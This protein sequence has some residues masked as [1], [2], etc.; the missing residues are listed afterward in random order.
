MT[1]TIDELG[2]KFA[3]PYR[4]E[5]IM[6]LIAELSDE[7]KQT[8][9]GEVL[10]REETL[11][12]WNLWARPKQ[13]IPDEPYYNVH[14]LL[15]GRGF[16]KTRTMAEWI[17]KKAYEE[18]GCRIG[19]LGRTAADSR[20]IMVTG[21]SGILNIPQPESQKP[22]YKSSEAMVKY[23]NG[24][25]VKLMSA[26]NPDGT[27]GQQFNYSVVDE[28]AAHTPFVGVDGLTA[29]Q[30]L[31]LATRLGDRP[32]LV[33]ATTPKKVK[34]LRDLVE[35]SKDPSKSIRLVKGK[36]SENSAN[37]SSVYMD[38]IHGS[39]D[40]T[41]IAR[42][43][44]DGEML[45]DEIE[46]ALWS[47]EMIK[48]RYIARDEAMR[49]PLR[50]V[51]VDPTVAERPND[52]CGIVVVGG[53]V[54]PLYHRRKGYVLA[55]E[56]LKASP[57]V[58][59]Q[60]VIDTFYEWKAH[61]IVVEKNQG[62]FLLKMALKNIDPAVASRIFLVN[63][64]VS[65]KLRA[66][67]ISQIYEQ[68]RILHA[69]PGYPLLESQMTTWEPEIMKNSPDRID[70]LVHGMTALL[71]E[72]PKGLRRRKMR[73]NSAAAGARLPTGLGTGRTRTATPGLTQT[74]F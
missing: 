50:I 48:Y 4:I 29:F 43:E 8:Y 66:E 6:E 13:I 15:A 44:L 28:F 9:F 12:D 45:D 73:A 58:W 30:S 60:K 62:N 40:G 56:S 17:R 57:E 64:S 1:L 31:R 18:P 27:R 71:V 63:A 7:D 34:P 20:D 10:S 25:T 22:E 35:E 51:A 49:L 26:E 36:T 24:S 59:A 37:L 47:E 68:G 70:A 39:F 69:E 41:S 74:R 32:M 14:L 21:E 3:N 16:G 11:Y 42:Q 54:D 65:K 23:P 52:E 67:P 33:V 72:E 19:I 55:D 38:V 46:G 53:T 61:G 2:L 5:S